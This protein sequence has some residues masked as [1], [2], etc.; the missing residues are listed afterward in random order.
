[1][2]ISNIPTHEILQDIRDTQNEITVMTR[3]EKGFR[4][5]GDPWSVMR[6]DS[7]LL[8]IAQRQTF[9]LKLEKILKARSSH[10]KETAR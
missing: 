2:K 9:V 7:R 1:M 6:A 8:G 4:I 5:I 3:E 10:Q